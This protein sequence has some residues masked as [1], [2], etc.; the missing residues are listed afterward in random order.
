MLCHLVLLSWRNV[1][2]PRQCICRPLNQPVRRGI[3]NPLTDPFFMEQSPIH[4]QSFRLPETVKICQGW[5]PTIVKPAG[6]AA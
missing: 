1:T 4:R 6:N 2:F 5:R 3:G